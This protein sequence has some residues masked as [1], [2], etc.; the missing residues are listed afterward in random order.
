MSE[1]LLDKRPTQEWDVFYQKAVLDDGSPFFPEKLPLEALETIRRTQGSYMYANQYLNQIIP[2]DDMRFKREWFRYYSHI[3]DRR[4]TVIFVDPAI[5]QEEHH[6][7]T[8]ITVVHGD[9]EMRWY[10][11]VAKRLRLTPTQTVNVIFELCEM[12]KPRL[13]GIEEVAYQK[14]LIYLI[15]EEMNKRGQF[16]PITGVKP[17]TDKTKE[18]KIL[19]VLVPRLE[20][21]RIFFNQGLHD[22][23]HELLTFPR[24]SHDDILDA[25]ASCDELMSYPSKEK[26]KDVRPHPG[27][28]AYEKEFIRS[29][30]HR[31]DEED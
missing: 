18:M 21:G 3:P 28:A 1:G 16:I 25:L 5:G 23:E 15:H 6:D 24:G 19:S 11:E 10:V 12:F 30:Q 20:Y 27:T 13:I 31:R 2:E 14:A 29:L 7:F 8:G 9:S 22:L 26:P 17:P 4:D